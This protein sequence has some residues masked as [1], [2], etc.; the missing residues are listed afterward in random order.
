MHMISPVKK[1]SLVFLFFKRIK[2]I[3]HLRPWFDYSSISNLYHHYIWFSDVLIFFAWNLFC[4][5]ACLLVHVSFH[6][7][8]PYSI[9]CNQAHRKSCTWFSI[10]YLHTITSSSLLSFLFSLSTF[11]SF[12]SR[13]IFAGG[14]EI[15]SSDFSGEWFSSVLHM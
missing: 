4:F 6:W 10:T 12:S 3:Y 1:H 13:R 15:V 14:S 5:T 9:I 7:Y 2:Q 8:L 11:V